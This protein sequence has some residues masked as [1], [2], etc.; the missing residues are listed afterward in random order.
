MTEGARRK[1]GS[2]LREE[3]VVL[4]SITYKDVSSGGVDGKGWGKK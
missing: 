3:E 2:K 4:F 1:E